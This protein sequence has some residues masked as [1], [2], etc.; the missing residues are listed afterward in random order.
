MSS[1]FAPLGLGIGSVFLGSLS[2]VSAGFAYLI[3]RSGFIVTGRTVT[4]FSASDLPLAWVIV[5][6]LAVVG[7][8]LVGSGS[9]F[10]RGS[11]GSAP[12]RRKVAYAAS[13]VG[14]CLIVAIFLG[15]AFSSPRLATTSSSETATVRQFTCSAIA[16]ASYVVQTDGTYYYAFNAN[17]CT[18][19]YG[20]PSSVGGATGTSFSSVFNHAVL[21]NEKVVF[22][23]GSF[24][25][26][27]AIT[28]PANNVVMEG[29]GS[30]TNFSLVS[31]F[32]AIPITISG[33]NWLV[34]QI[35]LD[36]RNLVLGHTYQGI[37]LNGNNDT[38]SYSYFNEG[39]HGQIELSG[40]NDKALYNYIAN[41]HDDGIILLQGAYNE[42]VG[43]YVSRTTN[44]NCISMVGTVY[45]K[46]LDNTC[47]SSG[48][49]GIALEN[50]GFGTTRNGIVS[51]NMIESSA[52]A[53][54]ALYPLY[55]GVSSA[56]NVTI[57]GNQIVSDGG[58]AIE[59]RDNDHVAVL[60]NYI[61]KPAS[62]CIEAISSPYVQ[63]EGNYCEN[64]GNVG[65]SL[66]NVGGSLGATVGAVVSGN[67][68]VASSNFGINVSPQTAG[69]DSA[70]NSTISYNMVM[71][72]GST[73]INILSGRYISVQ[74]N[75]IENSPQNGILF[76]SSSL[77]GESV[78]DN[79]I[80]SPTKQGIDMGG[81]VTDSL[82][83]GNTV[84]NAAP[85]GGNFYGLY[86]NAV[87]DS[88][89]SGNS[90]TMSSTQTAGGAMAVVGT[91]SHLTISYNTFKGVGH[92]YG[93]DFAAAV[94]NTIVS[95][96]MFDSFPH[97]VGETSGSDYNMI[98]NNNFVT[99][100][101]DPVYPLVGTHD[102][103]ENNLG[104]NPVGKI[105]NPWASSTVGYVGGTGATPRVPGGTYTITGVQVVFTCSGGGTVS[106]SILDGAG[107]TILSGLTCSTLPASLWPVGYRISIVGNS[108]DFSSFAVY[109]D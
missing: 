89:I 108:S 109:G 11:L 60:D 67:T 62:D 65:I 6:L 28:S 7:V 51:D 16:T 59:L 80:V 48:S 91:S 84:T 42:A 81:T 40:K 26:D 35:R 77:T 87:A 68:V 88:T 32:D 45:F 49:Y 4:M 101:N 107:N 30:A 95:G 34:T 82:I 27:S 105:T 83:E 98:T 66:E 92:G 69:V 72:P 37:I 70:D 54:I 1:R 97:G 100:V 13:I 10:I 58:Y 73:G 63:I 74:G 8:L 15:S 94:T 93:I 24:V 106:I 14:I 57:S 79:S 50:V 76:S 71:N 102:I 99:S 20:G 75:T 2:L 36:E 31:P 17:T 18:L 23:T 56:D 64:S 78:I 21:S 96:N 86:F 19:S 38:V 46:V 41:S 103:L 55:S 85:R 43:N 25:I 53:G 5:A 44:H 33:S 104:L 29:Q 61:I 52:G 9:W 3:L 12:K 22:G 39:D 47:I 90:V